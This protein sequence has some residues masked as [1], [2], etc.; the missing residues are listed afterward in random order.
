MKKGVQKGLIV[1]GLTAVVGVSFQNCS[2]FALQDQVLYEQGLYDS[3]EALDAKTLPQLLESDYLAKWSKVGATGYVDHD[4]MADQ[5]SFVVAAD[6]K[7]TGTIFT[8]GSGSGNEISEIKVNSGKISLVRTSG[9]GAT[10]TLTVNLP[11]EGDRMVI[12]AALG[13]KAG[14]MSLMVNGIVQSGTIVKTGVP[15]E[16]SYIEKLVSKG[17][18]GGQVYEYVVYGGD[19]TEGYGRLTD[20]ELNVMSRYIANNNMI[21]NV[22]FDPSLLSGGSGTGGGGS[23]LDPK[24]VAAKNVIDSKCI[25]CHNGSQAADFKN[26]SAAKAITKGVVVAGNPAG[27]SL[28]FRLKGSS[29]AGTK[30]MPSDSGISAAEVQAIADWISSIQ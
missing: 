30:N 16:F 12:A 3:R 9:A 25:H 5:W 19:S 20:S 13:P 29:G 17:G 22:V 10:E 28:Y 11:S 27:S 7:I 1:A 26:I 21:A 2:D 24:F 8:V 18:S 6:R 15:G 23:Q 4:F 14:E